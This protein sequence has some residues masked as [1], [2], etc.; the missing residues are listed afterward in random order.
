METNEKLIATGTI[1]QSRLQD[2]KDTLSSASFYNFPS[3]VPQSDGLFQFEGPSRSI[4]IK[5]HSKLSEKFHAVSHNESVRGG[6]YPD[7][8]SEVNQQLSQLRDDL[9][10]ETN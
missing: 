4:T 8:F 7:G 3:S 9:F 2:L 10:S 6:R 5:A 1:S